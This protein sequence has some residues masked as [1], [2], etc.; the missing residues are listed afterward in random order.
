[1]IFS[2]CSKSILLYSASRSWKFENSFLLCKLNSVWFCQYRRHWAEVERLEK[3]RPFLCHAGP[4]H[5]LH[6]TFLKVWWAF[7]PGVQITVK[8]LQNQVLNPSLGSIEDPCLPVIWIS[9]SQGSI[10]SDYHE[11]NPTFLRNLSKFCPVNLTSPVLQCWG[12]L[13]SF[14]LWCLRTC[15][16]L[17]PPVSAQSASSIQ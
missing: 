6:W 5:W 17:S 11:T 13:Q 16:I 10:L 14:V 9:A 1:M 2:F 3:P 4:P 15:F 7:V 8:E 12:P